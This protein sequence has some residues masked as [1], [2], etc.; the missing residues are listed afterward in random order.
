MPVHRLDL[1]PYL[2]GSGP[3][4]WLS[5]PFGPTLSGQVSPPGQPGTS[6]PPRP[7]PS[8]KEGDD[9]NTLLKLAASASTSGPHHSNS[10]PSMNPQRPPTANAPMPDLSFDMTDM[11]GSN[12][13][14]FDFGPTSFENIDLWFESI[15]P[16]AGPGGVNHFQTYPVGSQS[17][18]RVRG[19][20]PVPNRLS[21]SLMPTQ[22]LAGQPPKGMSPMP[23]LDQRGPPRPPGGKEGEGGHS[24][25]APTSGPHHIRAPPMNQ[26]P[27]G[28]LSFDMT[29]MF[30]SNG[31]D[32][33]FGPTSLD[34]MDLWFD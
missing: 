26:G 2:R 1:Q 21:G 34:D 11:F 13:E 20:D 18:S 5:G 3:P 24:A 29:D 25:P 8:V 28:D 30:G 10:T 19:P 15:P 23:P 16:E 22:S 7:G 17:H 14:D 27:M 32:F 31:G 6:G 12:D 4:N 9:L 33:D